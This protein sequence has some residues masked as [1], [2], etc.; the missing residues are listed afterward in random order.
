MFRKYTAART[1]REFEGDIIGTGA[2]LDYQ[3]LRLQRHLD[4]LATLKA[5]VEHCTI[6]APHDGYVIYANYLRREIFIEEGIPVYQSQ[7]LFYLPDL[8]DMEVVTL[9]SESV[10]NQVRDGMRAVV[11]IEGIPN[12]SM[13]GRIT[14][15]A[16]LPLPDW[17]NDVHYFEGIVK[18]EDP[19][20]GLKPGMTAQVEL[21]MPGRE[22]VL[23]VRSE[24]VTIDDG[25]DVCFV[26]HE[27]GLERREVKLGQVTHE[28]TEVTQGLREGEQ[29]VLNPQ[30]LDIELLDTPQPS[31][32]TSSEVS[33]ATSSSAEVA[34]SR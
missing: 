22:N 17:R 2:T 11:R 18:L 24:A 3:K 4:R 8:S 16:Q 20:A 5:Q 7:K 34:A 32:A 15:V 23:A 12:R 21:E 27:E 33:A 13:H 31:P 28:M 19:P 29:V 26:V 14:K 9:L 6:R 10:V 30:P 25:E 1:I